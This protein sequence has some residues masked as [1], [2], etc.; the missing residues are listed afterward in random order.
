MDYLWADFP[1]ILDSAEELKI[2]ASC[3]QRIPTF[4]HIPYE[5]HRE[6]KNGKVTLWVS[7]W[8]HQIAPEDVE[9]LRWLLRRDIFEYCTK[10]DYEIQVWE[11]RE[12][13]SDFDKS[14]E[15]LIKHIKT[16]FWNSMSFY[17]NLI[18][19]EVRPTLLWNLEKKILHSSTYPLILQIRATHPNNSYLLPE[20]EIEL[21]QKKC[22]EYVEWL[23]NIAAKYVRR[24][25]IITG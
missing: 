6:E 21:A 16:Q 2:I 9:L 18:D 24:V 4:R 22:I 10:Y 14:C 3:I 12:Q 25:S 15:D 5:V 20:E 19:V 8:F 11:N 1:D 17:M 23:R 13:E 7:F